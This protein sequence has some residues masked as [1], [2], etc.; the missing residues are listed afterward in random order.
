MSTHDI[1]LSHRDLI[2][3]ALTWV[4]R[5]HRLSKEDSEDFSSAFRVHLME[6][7]Y[8]VL[9][10]FEGRSRL[11]TYLMAV[12]AHYFQDWQNARWGKW[13]PS[14]AAKRTGP[15]AV[16]LET[17]T[18]RD[19]LTLDQACEVLRANYGVSESRAELEVIA[20]R[21]PPRAP[22]TFVSDEVLADGAGT[23]NADVPL[24]RERAGAIASRASQALDAAIRALP[25]EDRV[26]ITLRFDQDTR[27]ID[28]ARVLG[29][30]QKTLYR[31][32][33]KLLR[34]LRASLVS[35]G[36]D[37][38]MCRE[39]F[40]GRGFDDAD[41]ESGGPVRPYLRRVSSPTSAQRWP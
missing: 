13:R 19:G 30:E 39:A 1:Y 14:A 8:S 7:D 15:V 9:R 41:Q 26:I 28:I 36:V 38:A 24:A 16:R 12:I 4:C 31:R 6:D 27:V 33:E 37:A 22:R 32:I 5:R 35:S 34:E 3:R 21:L 10:A 18:V 40:E 2:E 17:L 29:V 20:A 23:L 25:N 11:Q